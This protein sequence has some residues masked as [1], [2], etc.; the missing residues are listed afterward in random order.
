V[1]PKINTIDRDGRGFPDVRGKPRVD[2]N[3][4]PFSGFSRHCRFRF[5]ATPTK[6]LSPPSCP[7]FYASFKLG[8]VS[9]NREALKFNAEIIILFNAAALINL[10]TGKIPADAEISSLMSWKNECL[11]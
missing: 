11:W 9:L 2:T 7:P 10:R 1:P 5:M 6:W 4:S 3:A 8:I